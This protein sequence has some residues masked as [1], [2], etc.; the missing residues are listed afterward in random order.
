[1]TPL[2]NC[3]KTFCSAFF[4]ML[5]GLSLGVECDVEHKSID[6]RWR[7]DVRGV[8]PNSATDSVRA[9]LRVNATHGPVDLRR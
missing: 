1:V 5:T 6:K 4:S 7:S 9:R 2:A 3:P 8:H